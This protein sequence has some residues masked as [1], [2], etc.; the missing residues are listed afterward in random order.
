ME[1]E[2]HEGRALPFLRCFHSLV[3]PWS[4]VQGEGRCIPHSVR[5]GKAPK[6]PTSSSGEPHGRGSCGG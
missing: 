2:G 6:E 5:D 3:L 4:Q 1:R